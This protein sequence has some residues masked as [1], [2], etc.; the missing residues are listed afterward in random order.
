MV[1]SDRQLFQPESPLYWVFHT[2]L[3][4]TDADIKHLFKLTPVQFRRLQ[5]DKPPEKE[6]GDRMRR[7]LDRRAARIKNTRT[8]DNFVGQY[9]NTIVRILK[10]IQIAVPSTKVFV[11]NLNR[12]NSRVGEAEERL[13]RLLRHGPMAKKDVKA[14][15][16]D[17]DFNWQLTRKA[18]TRLGI[19]TADK[20]W[21]LL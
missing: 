20:E 10:D 8:R 12:K 11:P 18:A 17:E 19:D 21:E 15:T 5:E 9:R 14:I 4:M 16:E 1:K 13:R 3:R 7:S 6:T 2:V